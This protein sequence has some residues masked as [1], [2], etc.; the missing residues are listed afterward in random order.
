MMSSIFFG[1]GK[2]IDGKER[3]RRMVRWHPGKRGKGKRGS[4][5]LDRLGMRKK[6]EKGR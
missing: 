2:R 1:K 5:L 4:F 6:G 3:L